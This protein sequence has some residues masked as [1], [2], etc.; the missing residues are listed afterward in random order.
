ML[1]HRRRE[2]P[3][4]PRETQNNFRKN[5]HCHPPEPTNDFVILTQT[6]SQPQTAESVLANHPSV[7]GGSILKNMESP[8][9][10]TGEPRRYTSDELFAGEIVY[11]L[12]R[13]KVLSGSGRKEHNTIEIQDVSG[14]RSPLLA[15]KGGGRLEWLS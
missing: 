7:D 13:N 11:K 5:D 10:G 14:R 4:D 15:S 1:Y 6:K 9:A 12:G 2:G 3:W 8:K